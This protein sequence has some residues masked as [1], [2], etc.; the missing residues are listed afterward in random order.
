MQKTQAG[1]SPTLK[2]L[3]CSKYYGARARA[4]RAAPHEMY[5]D[6]TETLTSACSSESRNRSL[7]AASWIMKT[8]PS[9]EPFSIQLRHKPRSRRVCM[10][11]TAEHRVSISIIYTP[12]SL[13]HSC[14]IAHRRLKIASEAPT[15]YST[16]PLE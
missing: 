14:Y 13:N 3:L 16:H 8:Q 10:S 9:P 15:I 7:T 11:L 6:I 2:G 1:F 5:T 12:V 4:R